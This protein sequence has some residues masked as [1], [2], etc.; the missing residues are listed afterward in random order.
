MRW[1]G[2]IGVFLL[3]LVVLDC[4]Y[5]TIS[6]DNFPRYFVILSIRALAITVN[7]RSIYYAVRP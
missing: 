2:W 7:I 1:F 6:T 4:F 5:N 3:S